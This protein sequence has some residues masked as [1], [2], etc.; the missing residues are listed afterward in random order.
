M[1]DFA[2]LAAAYDTNADYEETSSATK[3]RA[4]ITAC[5][6]LLSPA[7]SP[8]R[9]VHGG[10]GAEEIE[11]DLTIVRAE[12]VAA[13]EWLA[14]YVASTGGDNVVHVDFCGFRD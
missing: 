14:D 9:N 8:K 6:R 10:R 7:V 1:S 12:L 5:R 2:T 13:Q 4:F 3:A 11:L